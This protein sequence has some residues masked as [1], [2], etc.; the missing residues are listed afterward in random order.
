[1]SSDTRSS[2]MT[3]PNRLER[4]TALN[5]VVSRTGVD[6]RWKIRPREPA[7][8]G[9]RYVELFRRRS[10]V[11]VS[12][13]VSSCILA[14]RIVAPREPH[15]IH[16]AMIEVR[17]TA[18]PPRRLLHLLAHDVRVLRAIG[19]VLAADTPVVVQQ[20]FSPRSVTIVDLVGRSPRH[21][22]ENEDAVFQIR[23]IRVHVR[24]EFFPERGLPVLWVDLH[25]PHGT[26]A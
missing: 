1:M 22:T 14:S 9:R 7:R 25:Q 24:A 21:P 26:N 19:R 13:I 5:A 20:R 12:R 15:R 6:I 16:D 4:S 3:S 23:R 8:K 17:A 10:I 18:G 2:A 11:V